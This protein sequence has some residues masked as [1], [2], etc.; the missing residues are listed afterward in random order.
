MYTVSMNDLFNMVQGALGQ[1]G[2]Q[3]IASKLG[4]SPEIAQQGIEKAL[5]MMTG[6]AQRQ[7]AN[8]EFFQQIEANDGGILDNVQGHFDQHDDNQGNDLLGNLF[9]GQ[10]G[11][12]AQALAGQSNLNPGQAQNLM[13]MLG[14][15]LMGA[16]GKQQTAQGL[17]AD[18][19]QSMLGGM[20][21]LGGML[22]FL[23]KDKD[24]NV[25]EEVGDMLGG[26]LGGNKQ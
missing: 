8:P 2:I 11:Q 14:P 15:L 21:N 10:Q 16:M 24:G 9:G 12:A 5:P 6:G 19:L 1:G 3:Q 4:V 18:G 26:F 22:G 25:M 17:N 20:G 13:G 7:A 23:D